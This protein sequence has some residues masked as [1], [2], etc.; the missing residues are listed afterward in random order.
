MVVHFYPWF[1]FDFLLLFSM[2]IYDNETI[3]QK[4]IKIKTKVKIEIQHIHAVKFG[5]EILKCDHS[6]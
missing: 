2:L 5:D 3:K 6:N 1:K 4:K